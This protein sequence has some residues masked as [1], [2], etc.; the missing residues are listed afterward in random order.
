MNP[1]SGH[2]APHLDPG[3]A[4]K[5][6]DQEAERAANEWRGQRRAARR[7]VAGYAQSPEDLALLLEALELHPDTDG[8]A[9]GTRRTDGTG[10][11]G[12]T[13]DTE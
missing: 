10:S 4:N 13:S 3:E 6:Q 5:G 8:P 2:P 11:K 1:P 12:G 9:R 7:V